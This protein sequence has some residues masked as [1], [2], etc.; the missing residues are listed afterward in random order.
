M[1]RRQR[2]IDLNYDDIPESARGDITIDKDTGLFTWTPRV[3][4][5]YSFKIIASDG[6]DSVAQ[7][8]TLP[9]AN[10]APPVIQSW[11]LF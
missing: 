5:Q 4:G 2:R 6:R 1:M 3:S 9:V 11:K 8:I 7:L 10:N